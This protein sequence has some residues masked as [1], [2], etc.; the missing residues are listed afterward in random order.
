MMNKEEIKKLKNDLKEMYVD[1][2]YDFAEV[3]T[4]TELDKE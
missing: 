2:K 1:P 3:I 4:G